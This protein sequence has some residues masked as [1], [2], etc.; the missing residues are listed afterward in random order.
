MSTK[1]FGSR[2]DGFSIPVGNYVLDM[3]IGEVHYCNNHSYELS[4]SPS[5]H[6]PNGELAIIDSDGNFVTDSI[7]AEM[8]LK[9]LR[10]DD[11][12]GYVTPEQFA[13]IFTYLNSKS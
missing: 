3:G 2:N 4:H 10:G 12:A 6:C 5:Y 7:L 8:G 13:Q 1:V 11:V 9:E